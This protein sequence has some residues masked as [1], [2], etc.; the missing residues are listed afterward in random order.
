MNSRFNNFL[1]K[2]LRIFYHSFPLKKYYNKYTKQGWL[3]KGFKISSQHKRDLYIL[4]KGTN[5]SKIINYY[6][7]YCKIQTKVMKTAKRHHFNNLIK[8]SKNKTKTTWN[9]VKAETNN[10][11][12]N[13]K[14][15]LT[16]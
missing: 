11:D 13:N 15:P 14:L 5:N 8:H 3:T 7:T 1:N 16:V 4:C 12:S 6:K 9:M 2:Y 10:R